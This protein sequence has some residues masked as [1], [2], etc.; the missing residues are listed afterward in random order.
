MRWKWSRRVDQKK[1]TQYRVDLWIYQCPGPSESIAELHRERVKRMI[2]LSS[3]LSWRSALV[4]TTPIRNKGDLSAF[5]S[6][7]YPQSVIGHYGSYYIRDEEYISD[8]KT[9]DDKFAFEVKKLTAEDYQDVLRYRFPE[10][11]SAMH[12]YRAVAYVGY[13]SSQYCQL[14]ESERRRLIDQ[15]NVDPDGRNNVF[16][17]D[18]A[19]FWDGELCQRALG[20]GRDEVIKRLT[21]KVPLV[22]P[23]LDG[24]YVVFND[25]PD[26][27]FEE[28]CA[29]NDRLKPVLGL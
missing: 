15:R 8:D 3:S 10:V 22:Q 23:L 2:A 12:G 19:K 11:I 9:S 27:T 25:D 29:Y 24:V 18:V 28:F 1:M 13:H 5:Y 14:H 20:Y 21:G 4:P 26:L 16:T 17:L 7:K 6:V